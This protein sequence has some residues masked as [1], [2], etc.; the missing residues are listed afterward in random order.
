MN[1]PIANVDKSHLLT[2]SKTVT[3]IYHHMPQFRMKRVKLLEMTLE[4]R[5]NFDFNIY[6]LKK[7]ASKKCHALARVI[8]W[9]QNKRHV[10]MNAFIKSQFSY[11]L[12]I[13]I[14]HGKTLNNRI[15]ILHKKKF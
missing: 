1:H 2:S 3:D 9:T 15:N 7:K 11:Y 4:G 5:L 14:F 13:W 10:V 6:T 12:L 8:T